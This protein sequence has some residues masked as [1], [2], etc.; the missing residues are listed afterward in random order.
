MRKL[1][2]VTVILVG[3][4]VAGC[5]KQSALETILQDP[6]ARSHLMGQLLAFEDTRA[7]V[8]D[9]IFADNELITA[10]LSGYSE[11]ELKR[12]V[13]LGHILAADS[14][15]EWII[16]KLVENPDMKKKMRSA[17]RK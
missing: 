17:S 13:L 2:L 7:E 6:G 15:G 8:A 1:F 16:A 10:R 3:I 4:L 11:D 9:S 5:G 14:T 12:E